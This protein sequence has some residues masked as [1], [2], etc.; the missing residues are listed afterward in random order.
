MTTADPLVVV[1]DY[2]RRQWSP[3]P[4]PYCEKAPTI[5]GWPSLRIG[6][7]EAPHYFN[8]QRQNIGILVGAPSNHLVDVDLDCFEALEL[9][10]R[11][12]P[13]TQSL[14]G[15][16]SKRGAHHIYKGPG[17]KTAK[18]VDPTRPASQGMLLE[19]R[20]T[21]SQTIFPGSTHPSGEPIEWDNDGEPTSVAAEQLVRACSRLAAACLVLRYLG[22]E[23][24]EQPVEEWIGKLEAADARLGR[25]ARAWL[26]QAA[27]PSPRTGRAWS[28]D[29]KGRRYALAALAR[30]AEEAAE[31]GPG[32]QSDRLNQA[33]RKLAEFAELTD[34]EITEA[35]LGATA[36]WRNDPE[37]EPWTETEIRRTI[38]SGIKAGREHPVRQPEII[39][40][41]YSDRGMAPSEVPWPAVL[42]EAA[43]HGLAGEFVHAIEPHTEADP[44]ALLMQFLCMV[45]NCVGRESYYPVGSARHCGNLDFLLVGETSRA[46]KGTGLAEVRGHLPAE[47]GKWAKTCISSGLSSGEGLIERVRDRQTKMENNTKTGAQIEI[48][49]D[50]GVSDKRL[51]VIEEEFARPLRV[52]ARAEN[53]LSATLRLAWDGGDLANLTRNS[54]L[55][56][57][58]PHVS[59]IGHCTRYELKRE[60][61]DVSMANGFGNR[62]LFYCVKRSKCLPFGGNVDP[63]V[64]RQLGGALPP[65]S[66]RPSLGP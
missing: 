23:V 15:R 52:M 54:P 32:N 39:R 11:Y 58:A 35:L 5:E 49:I 21:D 66:S 38:E 6:A 10:D 9:A 22:A 29:G 42:G 57:T 51:L 7:L 55:Y 48:E 46:R 28:G 41:S 12:L 36:R 65:L 14:F 4:V 26:G 31:T 43:Y 37:R 47:L 56:A 45:G 27:A 59:I 17:M 44:V 2:C 30:E 64:A 34:H 63:E 19:A 18:F 62:V 40:N 50:P 60:L 8:G 16:A 24:L 13:A 61:D 20:S 3:I 25:V 33:A 53:T 1:L